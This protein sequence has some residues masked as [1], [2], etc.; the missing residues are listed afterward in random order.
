MD[1]P[2]PDSFYR[3]SIKGLITNSKGEFLLIKSSESGRW[4]LPWWGIDFWETPEVCLRREIREEMWLGIIHFDATPC[5]FYTALWLNKKFY[6][7]AVV[8]MIILE[9]LDFTPT[10][11]CEE[12]GF[13]TVSEAMKLHIYPKTEVFLSQY[14]PSNHVHL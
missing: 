9:S 4:D 14:N 5:Y 1:I 3:L 13:F 10:S 8:Y 2:T 11:E 7:A 12:I 6:V